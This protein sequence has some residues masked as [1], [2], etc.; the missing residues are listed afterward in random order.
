MSVFEV[1]VVAGGTATVEWIGPV[2]HRVAKEA[3]TAGAVLSAVCGCAVPHCPYGIPYNPGCRAIGL[4]GHRS[5]I[6]GARRRA[7]S[8]PDFTGGAA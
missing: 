3:G 8:L 6:V 2:G 4:H 7:G 1:L 5:H